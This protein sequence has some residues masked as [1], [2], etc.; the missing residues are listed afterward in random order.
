[1]NLQWGIIILGQNES[2]FIL[3]PSYS[4]ELLKQSTS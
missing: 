1:M 4:L 2:K 3:I